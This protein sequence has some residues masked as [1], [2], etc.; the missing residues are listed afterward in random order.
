MKS[1]FEKAGGQEIL[2][3][4]TKFSKEYAGPILTTLG[5]GAGA[6]SLYDA[7][8]NSERAVEAMD[9]A[10]LKKARE[11]NPGTD[12][13]CSLGKLEKVQACLPVYKKTIFSAG[14]ATG[15]IIAGQY[16]S[17]KQMIVA[18]AGMAAMA[19]KEKAIEEIRKVANKQLG[20]KQTPK[21]ELVKVAQTQGYVG[22][23]SKN[24]IGDDKRVWMLEPK[25]GH[26]VYLSPM[27]LELV[28]SCLNKGLMPEY[29]VA[30][31]RF[32]EYAGLYYPPAAE[33]QPECGEDYV[34]T[35]EED[36]CIDCCLKGGK[37]NA[38]TDTPYFIID[39]TSSPTLE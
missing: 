19:N 22:N 27:E 18:T 11:I 1:L 39:W 6:Y 20:I 35:I 16:T 36:G 33:I 26:M 7:I 15:C 28:L 37:V 21:E 13:R 38:I 25:A 8:T 34:W 2:S 29:P 14:V 10:A 32:Y 30:L 4:I 12:K 5:L 31:N 3:G 9:E 17:Y 23:P 24:E